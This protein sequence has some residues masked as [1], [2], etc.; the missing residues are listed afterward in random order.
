MA[1]PGMLRSRGIKKY[2][3]NNNNNNNNTNNNKV[4]GW[5]PAR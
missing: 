4:W 1:G 5:P 3:N 2:N